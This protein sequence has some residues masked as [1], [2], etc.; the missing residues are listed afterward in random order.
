MKEA[1][2]VAGCFL[3]SSVAA[4]IVLGVCGVWPDPVRLGMSIG[5]LATFF[6]VVLTLE[7]ED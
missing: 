3:V 7:D 2:L 4:S 5:L 1:Q 6:M